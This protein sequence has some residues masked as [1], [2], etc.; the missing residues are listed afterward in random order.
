MKLTNENYYSAEANLAYMSVSQVKSFAQCE[1]A[2]MAELRGEY[3][4]PKTT[5]LLV[6]SYVDA[7]FDGTLDQFRV[8]NP[9]IF[10][11]DGALRAEYVQAE[12]IIDR[13]QRD[14]LFMEYMAG[15]KQAIR[16]GEVCGVPFKIKMDSYHAD[17]IVDL[18]VMR[19]M[20]PIMGKSF[21]E[22]WRYDWQ[23]AVYQAVEGNGLPFFLAVA[24]K[25]DVPNIEILQIPQWRLDE[26][27][28]E[29][30]PFIER[31][32]LVKAEKAEP[33]RC[34]VCPYCRATK[35][36]D[37]PLDYEFAGLS[38]EEIKAMKGEF[39]FG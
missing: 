28:A 9:E 1:A 37:K 25:E 6:G 39:C 18:K 29:M 22:H 33:T 16:T 24:T 11:K 34:G 36:L 32:A 27:L 14:P 26:C 5:A 8:I 35:V 38:N 3:T 21:V 30:R 31:A 15:E 4:R 7:W 23:G 20:R 13:V 17:K 12:Q 19:E 10:R 2:A